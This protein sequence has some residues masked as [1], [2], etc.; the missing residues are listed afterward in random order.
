M[1]KDNPTEMATR[2]GQGIAH[3]SEQ[4]RRD[5]GSVFCRTSRYV[6]LIKFFAIARCILLLVAINNNK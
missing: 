5:L 2:T 3:Y 4:K 1:A 6:L